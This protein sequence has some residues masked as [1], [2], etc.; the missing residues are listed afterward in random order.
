MKKKILLTVVSLIA[1]VLLLL[2]IVSPRLEPDPPLP[3]PNGYDDFLKAATMIASHT[4]DWNDPAAVEL[5]SLVAT[6]Q[7]GLELVRTGL[8]KKCRMPVWEMNAT[9]SSHLNDL[10]AGK[11]IAQAFAAANR[12]ALVEGRTNEAAGFALDC[13]RFGNEYAHG[14]VVIDHLVRIAVQ[15]I[16]RSGLEEALSGTDEETSKEIVST[17][18]DVSARTESTDDILERDAAWARRGRFGPSNFFGQLVAGFLNRKALAKA[19]DKF[20]KGALDLL[21]TKIH[22]AAH[23]FELEQG[24]PPASVHEL[25]PE[26]LEAVPRDP[27]TG[28]ELLLD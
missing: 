22:A 25:V 8:S 27:A 10:A 18:G 2:V 20:A 13:I 17:L 11:R 23:A 14:G 3:V 15:A 9:N 4:P 12:L 24:R 19:K 26:Y 21:R 6:N 16:G 5:A 1:M 7:P 28:N